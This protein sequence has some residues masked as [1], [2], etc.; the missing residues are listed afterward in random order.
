MKIDNLIIKWA[1]YIEPSSHPSTEGQVVH[2]THCSILNADNHEIIISGTT[3][4]SPRDAY[5]KETG[6]KI[7]LTR[8]LYLH[9]ELVSGEH[10]KQHKQFRARVWEIYRTLT[11]VP[12]WQNK[13]S[14]I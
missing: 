10:E 14:L 11:K 9:R 12:R 3:Q 4:C 8:A 5:D 6:R 1:Y 13:K 2:V 7:S